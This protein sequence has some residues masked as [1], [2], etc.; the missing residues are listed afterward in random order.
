MPGGAITQL[1]NTGLA[2]N[3]LYGA[4][5]STIWRGVTRQVSQFAFEDVSQTS[6]GNPDFGKMATFQIQ[7]TGDLA[8]KTCLEVGIP[9]VSHT[10]GQTVQWVKRLGHTLIQQIKLIIGSNDIVKTTGIGLDILSQM[11]L[12]QGKF[13]QNSEMIGDKSVLTTPAASIP[14]DQLLIELPFFFC[15]FPSLALPMIGLQG[16]QVQVEVTFRKA[17]DLIIT[18]DGA[19]LA[20][21]TPSMTNCQLWV[22]YIY[23]S[24]QERNALATDVLSY[25]IEQFQDNNMTQ[26]TTPLVRERLVFNMPLKVMYWVY[27]SAAN[28]AAKRFLDFS[29]GSNATW[30]GVDTMQAS[31]GTNITINNSDRYAAR[32][33]LYHGVQQPFR[34]QTGTPNIKGI[35]EY[36]FSLLPEAPMAT[37]TLNASRIDNLQLNDATTF[38][39]GT[40]YSLYAMCVNLNTLKVAKG[41]GGV[42]FSS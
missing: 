7:R 26:Y 6:N 10:T 11:L 18:S 21:G 23:L 30:G 38:A 12:P 4:V 33:A 8:Y 1:L 5:T 25:Q 37:S 15:R 28:A 35:Y 13:Q 42:V 29:D 20:S 27:V 34:Y 36:A 22:N 41:L 17:S 39:S 32:G 9:A 3:G 40:P 31:S 14:A 2:D 16:H 19:A 24:L